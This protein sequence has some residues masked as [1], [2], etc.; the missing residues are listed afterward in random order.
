MENLDQAAAFASHKLIRWTGPFLLIAALVSNLL[1][2]TDLRFQGLLLLQ[3]FAYG[4]AA[5]GLVTSRRSL[6]SR[7]ARAGTSFVVMNAAIG[8]GLCRYLIGHDTVIWKPTER[9]SWSHI[10]ATSEM[11]HA[12]EKRAA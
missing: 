11:V 7:L 3:A 4:A 2:A 8:V 12:S 1:L 10:P 6:A 9:S 5:Y